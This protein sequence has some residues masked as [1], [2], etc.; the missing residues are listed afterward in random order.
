MSR[1]SEL[2]R[3]LVDT[4]AGR[5]TRHAYDVLGEIERALAEEHPTIGAAAKRAAAEGRG[6]K[7]I[8]AA[9]CAAALDLSDVGVQDALEIVAH[10]SSWREARPALRRLGFAGDLLEYPTEHGLDLPCSALGSRGYGPNWGLP[11]VRIVA[12]MLLRRARRRS[13]RKGK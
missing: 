3:E 13:I 12:E 6:K 10:A 4:L 8:V 11:N 9:A 2:F 7:G 1:Y 5:G